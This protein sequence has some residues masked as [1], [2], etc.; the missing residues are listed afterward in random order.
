MRL[1]SIL[2]LASVCGLCTALWAQQGAAVP[3]VSIK[4]TKIELPLSHPTQMIDK[5][6][7]DSDGNVYA[8]VWAGDGSETARL[9]VQEITPEGTLARNFRV[10]GASQNTDVA[11]GFFVSDAGDV[12]QA[13]R[14]ANG[15][16]IVKFAK[17]GSVKSTVKLEA[18]PRLVDPWQLAV[19]KAGEY[20]LSGLTGKDHRTPYT[21]VF[22]T[23][24]KLVKEIY[25]PEDEEARLKAENGD[26]AYT[27]SNAGNRFVGFGD[28]AAGSDGNVY[29]LRGT[30]P[31]LVYVVSPAGQVVRKLHIDTGSPDFVAGDIKLHAGRL[32]IGFNGPNNLVMVTD[33]EGRTIASYA[34]D[35]H[36]PDWP[37][38]ACYDG[39]GFTFVTAYAEKELYLL[40]AK[41]Q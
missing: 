7:C 31:A 24:G 34:V 30:S 9:P 18:D 8:R 27:R 4:T 37:A 33:L 23:N 35:R 3:A 21:A 16:Y 14:M 20:L 26:T 10:A 29:L 19:F 1:Q 38:L 17:D 28:V 36:K 12:Y 32:A 22:E 13:A 5:T 15:V 40:K 6:T 39:E 2:L 41:L 25:E 11:E